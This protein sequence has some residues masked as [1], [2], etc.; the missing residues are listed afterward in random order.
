[1]ALDCAGVVAAGVV[2][3][4]DV[5]GADAKGVG[6][7]VETEVAVRVDGWL[8]AEQAGVGHVDHGVLDNGLAGF[9]TA[10]TGQHGCPARDVVRVGVF[11][12]VDIAS[13]N[14]RAVVD[15]G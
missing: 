2:R 3:D 8:R 13:T 5:D 15:R 11:I 4:G 1:P 7:G 6:R 10:A 12:D 9:I 14:G